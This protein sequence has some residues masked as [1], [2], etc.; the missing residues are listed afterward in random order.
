MGSESENSF[1]TLDVIKKAELA[2]DAKR[3]VHGQSCNIQKAGLYSNVQE[4]YLQG[5]GSLAGP[6]E[7]AV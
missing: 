4:E 3:R 5:R 7:K 6:E 2:K 1:L